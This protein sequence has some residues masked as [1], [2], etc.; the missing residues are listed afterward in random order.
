[1]RQMEIC[2]SGRIYAMLMLFAFT[3]KTNVF[4]FPSLYLSFFVLFL[5][6][7]GGNF[8]IYGFISL[9]PVDTSRPCPRR[10]IRL[11]RW[12]P[13][14]GKVRIKKSHTTALHSPDR[15]SRNCAKNLNSSAL[16]QKPQIWSNYREG[17]VAADWPHLVLFYS[18]YQDC[19]VAIPLFFLIRPKDRQ[20]AKAHFRKYKK[21]SVSK[22]PHSSPP[23]RRRFLSIIRRR[24][25]KTSLPIIIIKSPKT[26]I[27]PKQTI[28]HKKE[29][30][31]DI[32]SR[33]KER[34]KK[35]GRFSF[36]AKDF[37]TIIL[38]E[39]LSAAVLLCAVSVS[40]SRSLC[41]IQFPFSK[42]GLSFCGGWFVVSFFL[43]PRPVTICLSKDRCPFSSWAAVLPHK[44]G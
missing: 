6:G 37:I 26:A 44:K 38:W 31:K 24:K 35:L 9:S 12:L 7:N 8:D 34:Q 10:Q 4:S 32:N 18:S 30:R 25:K 42:G 36:V 29:I 11:P 20:H 13:Q 1:M 27:W 43:L 17:N 23:R 19:G 5:K 41:L 15:K 16:L 21:A 3:F 40:P 14:A 2:L 22:T 33:N 39:C 28:S